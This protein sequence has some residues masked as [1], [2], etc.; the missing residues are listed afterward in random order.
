MPKI[1]ET[2]HMRQAFLFLSS[3]NREDTLGQRINPFIILQGPSQGRHLS[4]S[5][6]Y[7]LSRVTPSKVIWTLLICLACFRKE[8][9]T[10]KS[11]SLLWSSFPDKQVL[12]S[13]QSI[14]PL[15][16]KSQQ[17]RD[18]DT[19]CPLARMESFHPPPQ[20]MLIASEGAS[21]SK[22]AFWAKGC[23]QWIRVWFLNPTCDQGKVRTTRN[24]EDVLIKRCEPSSKWE[25]TRDPDIA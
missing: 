3:G 12:K 24:Q 4:G 9:L 22:E 19:V 14:W 21:K 5:S 20:K 11:Q 2:I 7:C 18:E 16:R 10:T 13:P 1:W 6:C 23:Y 8:P 15:K 25:P 17:R